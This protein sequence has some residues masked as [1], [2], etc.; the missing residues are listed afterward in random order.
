M[1]QKYL[2]LI[3]INDRSE[4]QFSRLNVRTVVS[5]PVVFLLDANFVSKVRQL[6]GLTP[7]IAGRNRRY[8]CNCEQ[9]T[10][11]YLDGLYGVH[12]SQTKNFLIHFRQFCSIMDNLISRTTPFASSRYSLRFTRLYVVGSVLALKVF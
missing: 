1:S 5:T 9:L 10:N 7:D 8:K 12:F 11:I 6:L 2:T 4:W 3:D